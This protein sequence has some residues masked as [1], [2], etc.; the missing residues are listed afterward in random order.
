MGQFYKPVSHQHQYPRRVYLNNSLL[1]LLTKPSTTSH[2]QRIK[3]KRK[4][5]SLSRETSNKDQEI[6]CEDEEQKTRENVDQKQKGDSKTKEVKLI[7]GYIEKD[8]I[9]ER[10]VDETKGNQ[11]EQK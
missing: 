5:R 3:F 4:I 9:E 8:L 1:E 10:K 6:K 7:P 11:E 2:S